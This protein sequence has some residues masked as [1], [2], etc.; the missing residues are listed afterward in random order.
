MGSAISGFPGEDF[1]DELLSG[2][3]S[4]PWSPLASLPPELEIP[5]PLLLMP[6]VPGFDE[7]AAGSPAAELGP[8]GF[9]FCAKE[10]ALM[11]AKQ[12]TKP[13]AAIFMVST[14]LTRTNREG[15]LGSNWS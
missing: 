7:L 3:L 6:V 10:A 15:F 5:L 9:W 2:I 12:V 13:I 8:S 1:T 11:R 14:P 4:R